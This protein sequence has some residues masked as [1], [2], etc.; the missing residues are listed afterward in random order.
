MPS[1]ILSPRRR[2]KIAG[3]A[4]FKSQRQVATIFNVSQSTVCYCTMMSRLLEA[5][6]N[7]ITASARTNTP[8]TA[9]KRATKLDNTTLDVSATHAPESATLM[10][11]DPQAL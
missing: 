10:P 9:P 8:H 2:S 11:V 7:A 3:M 5:V 6:P 1:P 4:R